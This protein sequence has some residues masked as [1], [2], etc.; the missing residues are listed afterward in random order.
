[1][2]GNTRWTIDPAH[3]DIAFKIKHLMISN[4]KGRFKNYNLDA[5]TVGND[6]TTAKI[7]FTIDPN[8]IDTNSPDRDTH[9][10]SADFF[11][12]HHHGEIVFRSTRVERLTND[13]V[14]KL[15]GDLTIRGITKPIELE[16][17]YNGTNTDPWGN[18]KAGVNIE[19]TINRK[20]WGLNWNAALEAG[21]WLVGD[22]VKIN[23]DVQL[24]RVK[25]EVGDTN[26]TS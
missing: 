17:E 1:M 15:Y 11:D 21:G 5:T 8:S 9:L 7:V 2:N 22:N 14:F 10:R 25:E 18:V 24:V 6:F 16:V 23:C 26:L 20:D 19:G 3:T 12:I 13:D 4:V